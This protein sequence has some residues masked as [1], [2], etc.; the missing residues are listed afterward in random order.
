MVDV[1]KL[2]YE[3]I[4]KANEL[5]YKINNI[6]ENAPTYISNGSQTVGLVLTSIGASKLINDIST[7]IAINRY[8]KENP[9]TRMTNTEIKRMLERSK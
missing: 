5:S 8:K 9:N 2:T 6:Q 7:D 3:E 4:K 1:K